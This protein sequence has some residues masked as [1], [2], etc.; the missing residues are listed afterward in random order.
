MSTNSYGE[1]QPA[2]PSST[3]AK[4]IVSMTAWDQTFVHDNERYFVFNRVASSGSGTSTARWT[5]ALGTGR[6][7]VRRVGLGRQRRNGPGARPGVGRRAGREPHGVIAL[8][9]GESGFGAEKASGGARGGVTVA[10]KRR[11]AE[12]GT[13]AVLDPSR[14]ELVAQGEHAWEADFRALP[15]PLTQSETHYLGLVVVRDGGP[16]LAQSQVEARPTAGDLAALLSQAMSRP[17][18]G[19]AARPRRLHVRGHPQWRELFPHLEALGVEVLVDRELPGV[20]DAY[21]EHL[22]RVRDARRATIARPTARQA[23]VE[24]AFPATTEWVRGHGHVEI[25]DQEGF[26]FVVRALDYGG[27]VF[28]DDTAD[29][30]AE[31]LAAL[32]KAL[33]EHF[34][35]GAAE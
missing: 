18:T 22:R 20:K 14:L 19:T 34:E 35:R 24:Q 1:I 2:I 8:H 4:Q 10:R 32:E 16:I 33:A 25:G 23:A 30:L 9:G 3:A 27:V 29:T 28:E 21:E 11:P 12:P 17:L 26:G 7:A 6:P 31:A 5:A 13:E 15:K